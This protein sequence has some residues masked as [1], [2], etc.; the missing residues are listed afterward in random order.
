V[1][2][3]GGD[4]LRLAADVGVVIAAVDRAAAPRIVGVLGKGPFDF[5]PDS[6]DEVLE[7]DHPFAVEINVLIRANHRLTV[8]GIAKLEE[9]EIAETRESFQ[10]EDHDLVESQISLQ[11]GFYDEMLKAANHLAVV[12]LVTRLQH[13]IAEFARARQL[14]ISTLCKNLGALN[15]SLGEVGPV[16]VLFFEGLVTARDSVIH[17]DSKAE[18]EYNGPRRV[19]RAYQNGD[20]LEVTEDQL[21]EAIENAIS[22]VKWYDGKLPSPKFVRILG[23]RRR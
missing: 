21:K 6:D 19:P 11:Q 10:Y 22:Q 2:L 20:D 5:M 3:D 13:W 15:D 16:P 8:D 14:R 1:R 18:W 23:T 9:Y 17:A 4:E 12:G 7:A